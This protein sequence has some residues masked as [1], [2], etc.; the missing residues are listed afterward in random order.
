MINKIACVLA[1][2]S[3]LQCTVFYFK[4]FAF[5]ILNFRWKNIKSQIIFS[6][7]SVPVDTKAFIC[8]LWTYTPQ[9]CTGSYP[10]PFL[11]YLKTSSS[12]IL[13]PP[14]LKS[15]NPVAQ[16]QLVEHKECNVEQF[17]T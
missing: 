16:F 7:I 12:H 17:Q 9:G 10:M 11:L 14:L 2:P 8:T 3:I 15:C 4:I 13:W 5:F 1:V 6:P